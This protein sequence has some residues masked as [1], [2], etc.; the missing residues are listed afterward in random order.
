MVSAGVYASLILDGSEGYVCMS[1]LVGLTL[2]GC[3]GLVCGPMRG[4]GGGGGGGGSGEI[5]GQGKES[6][7]STF[8]CFFDCFC[9]SSP[10]KFEIFLIFPYFLRSLVLSRSATRE[11]TCIP[12][13][14]Y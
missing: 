5:T 2:A 14:L 4:G 7:I 13:L 6:L 11:A 10:P 1:R 12:S 9:Q 8:A 3:G